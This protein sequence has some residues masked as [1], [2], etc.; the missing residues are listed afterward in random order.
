MRSVGPTSIDG[1][2]FLFFVT[3]SNHDDTLPGAGRP[4]LYKGLSAVYRGGEWRL[5]FVDDWLC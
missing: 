2:L 5:I 1:S 3:V 4:I